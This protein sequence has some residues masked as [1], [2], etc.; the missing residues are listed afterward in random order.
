MSSEEQAAAYLRE[1]DLTLQSARTVFDAATLDDPLW[2]QVVKNGYDAIEQAVSAAIAAQGE[3]IPRKHPA[4]I[5]TFLDLYDPDDALEDRL[6]DWLRRR[7][8]AQYVDIR[9]DEVNI[10]HEQFDRGDAERILDDADAVL[11]YV[12]QAVDVS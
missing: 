10:P 11:T 7:S 5:N 9:G 12:R 1:A 6:L 8:D 4:K 3:R 2:A